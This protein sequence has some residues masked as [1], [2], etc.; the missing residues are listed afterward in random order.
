[1][2]NMHYLTLTRYPYYDIIL[3]ICTS[4]MI[5]NDGCN[6]GLRHFVG[7]C[8][9]KGRRLKRY[10]LNGVPK[11][12]R[13]ELSSSTLISSDDFFRGWETGVLAFTWF[14]EWPGIKADLIFHL[15]LRRLFN[16]LY[17]DKGYHARKFLFEH[18]EFSLL[19]QPRVLCHL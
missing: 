17:Y 12:S 5:G 10:R 13:P 9:P 14:T 18:K 4:W 1:M 16:R 15:V 3:E 11:V 6:L 19:E 8:V 2:P 7:E